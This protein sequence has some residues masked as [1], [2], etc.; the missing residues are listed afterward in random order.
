MFKLLLATHDGLIDASRLPVTARPGAPVRTRDVAVMVIMGAITAT[1]A[2][3]VRLRLGIPGHAIILSVLP[4]SAGLAVVPRHGTGTVI[5]LTA[6]GTMTLF[7]A[8]AWPVG[9]GVGAVA[10]ML[11]AGPAFDL[12]LARATGWRLH[13]GFLVAGI[14]ANLIAL[15]ARGGL[16]L[17]SIQ[18]LVGR[19]FSEWFSYAIVTY[20][21][22]GAVAGLLCALVMFRVT[23][24]RRSA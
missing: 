19:P 7:K 15:V 21:V 5:S 16:K 20:P 3:F 11:A 13:I 23:R 24:G 12:V 2:S 1:V 9:G 17:L 4:I 8:L 10:S 6:F 22:S 14:A 18:P